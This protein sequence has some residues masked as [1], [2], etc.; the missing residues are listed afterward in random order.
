MWQNNLW[1]FF[2][3]WKNQSFLIDSYIKS[4]CF[5]N[6]FP[7]GW[8]GGKSEK[9]RKFLSDLKR[10]TTNYNDFSFDSIKNAVYQFEN[11]NKEILFIHIR[12]SEEI[13]RAANAFSAKTLLIKR[14]GLENIITNY[15]DANVD[16]YPYDY[17]IE[18]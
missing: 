10:L 4:S 6:K 9:D 18:N 14:V 16:N 7:N 3:L 12:E 1:S 15:S 13:E 2:I 17:I 11:S 8:N 5:S